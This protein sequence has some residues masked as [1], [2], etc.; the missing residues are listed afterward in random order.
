MATSILGAG[1]ARY[2]VC[3]AGFGTPAKANALAGK[4][5]EDADGVSREARYINPSTGDYV[6]DTNGVVQ[7]CSTISQS[8]YLAMATTL[9]S[10]AIAELGNDFWTM[11]TI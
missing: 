1:L 8:V 6:I 9:G 5:L 2:G 7:G 3:I 4:I 11:K 10:S